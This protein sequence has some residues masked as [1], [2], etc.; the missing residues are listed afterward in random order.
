MGF[1]ARWMLCSTQKIILHTDLG[2]PAG[3][4]LTYI[5]PSGD[6]GGLVSCNVILA[7]HIL[8]DQIDTH[9]D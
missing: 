3:G 7:R 8:N 4:C 6:L 1:G 2:T 9:R 5:G